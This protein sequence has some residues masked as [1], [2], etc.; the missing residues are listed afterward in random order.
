MAK[1]TDAAAG[2]ADRMV[3][4]L[5]EMRDRGEYPVTL[6]QLSRTA[7]PEAPEDLIAK[8]ARGKG[9]TS[10]V[11]LAGKKDLDAPLALAEDARQLV[12]SPLLLEWVLGQACTPAAPAQ[13]VDKLV[14][15]ADKQ[16]Q[17]PLAE[18]IERQA[19]EGTL[20]ESVGSMSLRNKT[21][22]F[23][24]RMPPAPSPEQ[25][26]AEKLLEGLRAHR[27]QQDYPVPLDRLV[28]SVAPGIDP[29]LVKKALALEPFASQTI[30]G[31]PGAPASPVALAEDRRLLLDSPTLL[32]QALAAVTT[33][34]KR[35]AGIGE[36][37]AR[38]APAL[39]DD[40]ARDLQ[41]RQT[42][43]LWPDTMGVLIL[44]GQPRLYRRAHPPEASLV[45]ANRLLQEL[46]SRR[47]QENGYPAPL[48]DLVRQVQP[49]AG[50]TL[51]Q[52]TLAEKA[53]KGEAILAVA[54]SPETP[55][56]VKGDETTL[57]SS[58]LLLEFLLGETCNETNQAIPV[59]DLKKKLN[60]DLRTSFEQATNDRLTGFALPA[61]VGALRI[62]KKDHLFL[63]ADIN[64]SSPVPRAELEKPPA[65]PPTGE[66]PRPAL[67]EKRDFASTF[68]EAFDRLDRAR[69]GMNFVS[70]VD[71]RRA[72][73]LDRE[74]FDTGLRELRRS[75]RFTL[76]AAEGRHGLTPEEQEAAVREEGT[77][78]LHV[79]RK[80]L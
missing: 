35:L 26:V 4:S 66:S 8:A 71:L 78:L 61:G 3:Q 18:A 58:P 67:A 39:Q 63:I 53:F 12:E 37:I 15:K 29:K 44:D 80:T 33:P 41:R 45:L 73:P 56:V 62:K 46:L 72:L 23:L 52:K 31:L 70:L 5:G 13:A 22:L 36:V 48:S 7:D 49:G 57:A 50:A 60:K 28:D 51:I 20:P 65:P 69:G 75:G 30:I 59:A 9:F 68:G 19:R 55:V 38:V 2:L 11:V 24:R 32:E 54:G 40:L 74:T 1:K 14:K 43:G 76:N 64:T 47:D 77:L 6:R 42:E 79:S 17:G 25:A 27:S 21:C 34:K 16:L 10:Q